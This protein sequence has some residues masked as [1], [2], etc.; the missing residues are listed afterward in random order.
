MI[1]STNAT[2]AIMIVMIMPMIRFIKEFHDFQSQS[3][4]VSGFEPFGESEKL[5]YHG[6]YRNTE[7]G[8]FIHRIFRRNVKSNDDKIDL[9]AGLFDIALS[10]HRNEYEFFLV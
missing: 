7:I 9:F 3:S 1:S 5:Q 4:K 8:R 2:I 6:I 10:S